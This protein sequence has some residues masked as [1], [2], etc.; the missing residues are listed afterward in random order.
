VRTV[1][2]ARSRAVELLVLRHEVAVLRRTN[3]RPR[4]DWADRA[5]FAARV[6]RLPEHCV[7]I[8]RSRRTRSWAGIAASS[9]DDGI[10]AGCL[11]G[12]KRTTTPRDRIGRCGC[13]RR[14]RHR[15][16][17]SRLMAGS[18]VD[19]SWAGSST[20]TRRRVET[21]GQAPCL[22]S[23]TPT[24]CTPTSGNYRAFLGGS[25][26]SLWA[27]SAKTT[28]STA[29]PK[30]SSMGPASSFG[31]GLAVTAKVLALISFFEMST[32]CR[33]TG[34]SRQSPCGLYWRTPRLQP[35]LTIIAAACGAVRGAKRALPFGHDDR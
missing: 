25:G 24:G 6:A 4:L 30:A 10:C 29:P 27:T 26:R 34:W 9:A 20:S 12:T 33:S 22:R 23:G 8:V 14:A 11:P 32:I 13:G 5:V 35:L 21:A 31:S 17:P 15:R 18:G 7:A 19:R 28:T 3:P 2:G 16:F 1:W